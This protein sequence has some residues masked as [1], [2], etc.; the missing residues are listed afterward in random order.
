[1]LVT[2]SGDFGRGIGLIAW[3]GVTYFVVE[4]GKEERNCT[5]GVLYNVNK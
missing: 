5:V 2:A 4:R 3:I 1:M